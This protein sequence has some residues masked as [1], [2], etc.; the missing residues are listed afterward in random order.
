MRTTNVG[1]RRGS[2]GQPVEATGSGRI[3]W[4]VD[5]ILS[6]LAL[7]S[8]K[9]SAKSLDSCNTYF[10][11]LQVDWTACTISV[12]LLVGPDFS[13]MHFDDELPIELA[14]VLIH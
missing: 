8:N 10:Y 3:R 13:N 6:C 2:V 4:G 1:R 12:P 14:V 11:Y 9:G 5:P 7:Y